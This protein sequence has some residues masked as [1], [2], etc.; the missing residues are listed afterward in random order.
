MFFLLFPFEIESKKSLR[1][2]ES[3]DPQEE[4]GDPHIRSTACSE[5]SSKK[6]LVRPCKFDFLLRVL[7]SFWTMRSRKVG[8]RVV[9][10]VF[11]L[12]V[13]AEVVRNKYIITVGPPVEIFCM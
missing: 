2:A 13:A 6:K 11:L 3:A 7:E 8:H 4:K 10:C 12:V 9:F 5:E 1:E